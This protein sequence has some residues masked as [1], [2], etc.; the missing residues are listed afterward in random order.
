MRFFI[1]VAS[2][3]ALVA[4]TARAAMVINVGQIPLFPDRAG[5]SFAVY[6]VSDA[7]DSTQGL[8]FNAQLGDGGPDVGGV[9]ITP[10][11]TADAVGPGTLFEFNHNPQFDG[12]VP[13]S[14]V[15]LGFAAMAGTVSIPVGP[16]VLAILTFDTTGFGPGYTTT[17]KLKDTVNGD[18]AVLSTEGPLTIHN[19][20]ITVIPEP[21][22]AALG[23]LGLIGLVAWS[24]RKRRS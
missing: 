10:L 15:N 4:G 8:V 21:S 22:T 23:A 9:D 5:Q 7:L 16:S 2:A 13:P 19:G 17:L 6:L 12:S 20:S 14:F 24:W 18:T 1:V 3:L 11:V